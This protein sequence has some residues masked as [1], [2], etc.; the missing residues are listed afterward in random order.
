MNIQP[1]TVQSADY[2][3]KN[4][5]RMIVTLLAIDMSEGIPHIESTELLGKYL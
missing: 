2:L 5:V 4:T 3:Q 1:S